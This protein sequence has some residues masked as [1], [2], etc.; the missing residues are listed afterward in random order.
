MVHGC[1]GDP[2]LIDTLAINYDSKV[3]NV[4]FSIYNFTLI[5]NKL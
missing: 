5:V 2:V 1:D 4:S 3:G